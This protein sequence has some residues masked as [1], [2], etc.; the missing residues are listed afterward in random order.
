[1]SRAPHAAGAVARIRSRIGA[2]RGTWAAV[3]VAVATL[4]VLGMFST[5]KIFAV[6]DLVMYFWPKHR[7][8]RDTILGG[9]W[10][11]W[12]PYMGAG[13]SAAADALLQMFFVPT[14]LL[15]LLLP[16]TL[17]FNLWVGLPFPLAA[18]GMYLFAR[19]HL[20]RQ[21]SALAAIVFAVCG[22]VVSTGNFLN[23]SWSAAGV[24][25]VMWAAGRC[26]RR[27]G[28]RAFV[29][30]A[31]CA[32]AQILSGEPMTMSATMAWALAYAAMCAWD[33]AAGVAAGVRRLAI[34]FGAILAGGAVSA[35]QLLPLWHAAA[36]SVRTVQ[37][38]EFGWSMHPASLVE[39]IAPYLFGDN[40]EWGFSPFPWMRATGSGREPFFYSVYCGVPVFTLAALG[41]GAARRRW[42]LFWSAT[43]V[44]TLVL[45]FGNHAP[46]FP[47][48]QQAFAIMRSFRYP[49]KYLML[50][51]LA[52]AMLAGYGWQ[53]L[54]RAAARHE[55]LAWQVKAPAMGV[56]VLF[57]VI[58]Y[59]A[60]MMALMFRGA[61][62]GI[63]SRI[64]IAG[65]VPD[66]D[67]A[68]GTMLALAEPHGR[69]LLLLSAGTAFLLWV[70]SGGRRESRIACAALFVALCG[71]LVVTN[72]RI[73]VM[74]PM[75][76]LGKPDWVRV[77]Q[78]HPA[79]RMYFGGRLHGSM[80]ESNIDTPPLDILPAWAN[81]MDKRTI[82][83]G[84]IAL[85]P[86]PW[87][88]REA[89][90]FDL[91]ALFPFDYERL[92]ARFEAA[93]R[94]ERFRFFANSGVRDC[95]LPKPPR[96]GAVPL[97]TVPGF[98]QMNLY[99]C[100]PSASRV[101][102]IPPWGQVEPNVATQIDLLFRPDF[103]ARRMVL[104]YADPP[105]PSGV[106]GPPA[107]TAFARFTRDGTTEVDVDAG[108]TSQGGF[109]V[110]ADSFDDDWHVSVDGQD[111]PLLQANGL[112][113]A[114]RLV[115]GTHAVH[116]AYRPRFV[117]V[118]AVISLASCVGL[119]VLFLVTSPS[120][121]AKREISSDAVPLSVARA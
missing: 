96:P 75:E 64:A 89:L 118:G 94:E 52:L 85:V 22:P 45:A 25:W 104:L 29:V 63:I 106:A 35:V 21:A 121:A 32:A 116:F 60:T 114:V 120:R 83:Q 49:P 48:L 113:R 117:V 87:R 6:R 56:V 1:M 37:G 51:A 15:R 90:S 59:A 70:A 39:T 8:L 19:G 80:D 33:E 53:A 43:A 78:Q 14:M 99:E 109:L 115:P 100:D 9:Q 40:F 36:H 42:A 3:A 105:P 68:V 38:V 92:V 119:G 31:I 54:V 47:A 79:E 2:W 112:Y 77:A 30:L 44:I 50:G 98:Y 82:M 101:R 55:P 95:V 91:P 72:S 71:D 34:V 69:R 65:G 97:A 10:P 66:L 111:A 7:W 26:V 103:D 76:Y 88:M 67:V 73:N 41:L 93:P 24:P 81:A 57:A 74:M 20:S 23:M 12:D 28:G 17:G 11:W 58:G 110:L 84:R 108:V 46:L 86:S 27:P 5:S 18:L 61:L 4:P 13:Q 107:Q 102:V 16:E 62:I